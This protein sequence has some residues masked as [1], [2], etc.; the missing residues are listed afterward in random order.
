MTIFD[1]ILLI[2][3]GGFVLFGIWF[4]IIHT[5]GAIFG[6]FAG[7]FFAGLLYE[8]LGHWLTQIFG[9]PNLMRIFAFIFIFIIINRLIGFIFHIID[10]IFKFMHKMP[11]LKTINSTIGGV[12]GFFEGLLVIG[13][14]LFMIARFPISEWFTGVLQTS[15]LT[16]WFIKTSGI[17]QLMLPQILKNLEAVI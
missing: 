3:L 7:A 15:S 16:P 17:L 14:S 6:T 5:I 11:F 13:I 10:K 1:V 2:L 4:G 12:L 8:P 9:N